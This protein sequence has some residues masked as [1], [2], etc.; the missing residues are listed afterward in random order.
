MC[1][2]NYNFRLLIGVIIILVLIKVRVGRSMSMC[3]QQRVFVLE[4]SS[5]RVVLECF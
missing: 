2:V 3:V 1:C 5:V 4:S